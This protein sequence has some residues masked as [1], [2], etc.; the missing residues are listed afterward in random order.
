MGQNFFYM[1]IKF[2]IFWTFLNNFFNRH[3]CRWTIRPSAESGIRERVVSWTKHV[4]DRQQVMMTPTQQD[5]NPQ[6]LA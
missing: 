4:G 2:L 1:V 5:V 3:M 6:S